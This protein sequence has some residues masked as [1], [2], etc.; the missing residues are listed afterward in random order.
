MESQIRAKTSLSKPENDSDSDDDREPKE[1]PPAVAARSIPPPLPLNFM[2][3]NS[4]AARD[5]SSD[6]AL[7]S[8]VH[9]FQRLA[10]ELDQPDSNEGLDDIDEAVPQMEAPCIL[11]KNVNGRLEVTPRSVIMEVPQYF[12]A[13][14]AALKMLTK[15]RKQQRSLEYPLDEE[16]SEDEDD[17]AN[18]T[19][20]VMNLLTN[21]RAGKGT[22]SL[23]TDATT[24]GDDADGDAADYGSDDGAFSGEVLQL[25][26][27]KKK[28]ASE[29][30]VMMKVFE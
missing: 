9:E 21:M 5:I 26:K 15:L 19:D 6:R 18:M 12:K 7:N 20:L 22:F 16:E 3:N 24:D 17:G 30:N 29:G 1:E 28:S 10:S 14:S 25:G 2:R 11:P 27:K 8:P 13:A 4:D 23:G